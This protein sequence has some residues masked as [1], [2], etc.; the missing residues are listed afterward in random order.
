MVPIVA[1]GQL[2]E[3]GMNSFKMSIRTLCFQNL[4]MIDGQLNLIPEAANF[5]EANDDNIL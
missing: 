2:R 5:L 1:N 4:L 3:L